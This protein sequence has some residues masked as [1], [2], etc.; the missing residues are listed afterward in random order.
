MAKVTMPNSKAV[1]IVYGSDD[2]TSSAA[3]AA[4][5]TARKAGLCVTG[6]YKLDFFKTSYSSIVDAVIEQAA[7]GMFC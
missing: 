1:T 7:K 4:L 6:F 2:A 3:Y 5:K